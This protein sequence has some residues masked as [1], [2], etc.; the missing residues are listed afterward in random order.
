MSTAETEKR[1]AQIRCLNCF[2]RFF[3]EPGRKVA[4]CPGCEM[5]WRLTWTGPHAVKVRG[6]V[7][8]KVPV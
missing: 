3:P 7:W 4:R 6:P 8:E 5:E 1:K 2:T